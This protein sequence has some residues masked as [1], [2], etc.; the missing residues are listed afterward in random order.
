M[1][2]ESGRGLIPEISTDGASTAESIG[3]SETTNGSAG[4]KVSPGSAPSEGRLLRVAA[5]AEE[6]RPALSG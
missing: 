4:T 5:V 1:P 6:G 3:S 2:D